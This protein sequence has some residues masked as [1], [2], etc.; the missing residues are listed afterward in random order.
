[1]NHDSPVWASINQYSAVLTSIK[2]YEL[3]QSMEMTILM[4]HESDR[5]SVRSTTASGMTARPGRRTADAEGC[6]VKARES[7]DVLSSQ[8]SDLR[9]FNMI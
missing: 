8:D 1:M 3:K 9:R 7:G 4:T 6:T 5:T 2:H